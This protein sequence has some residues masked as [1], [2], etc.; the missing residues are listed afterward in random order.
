MIIYI[1]GRMAGNPNYKEEFKKAEQGLKD[2]GHTVINPSMMPKG[3]SDEKYMPI[4]LAM[5]DAADAIYLLSGWENSKGAKL[6]RM[7]AIYQR[8]KVLY[9]MKHKEG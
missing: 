8:K 5:L 6:E 7:Y 4:C 3:L 1:A 2:R 9:E